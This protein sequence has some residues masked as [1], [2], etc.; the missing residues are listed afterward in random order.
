MQI[1]GRKPVSGADLDE[2]NL[3]VFLGKRSQEFI[4]PEVRPVIIIGKK[5][6]KLV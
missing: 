5:L 1:I 3:L 2:E 4:N 6:V